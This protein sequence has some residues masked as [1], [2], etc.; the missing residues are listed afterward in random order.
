MGAKHSPNKKTNHDNRIDLESIEIKFLKLES[1]MF[2]LPTTM[3]LL[4]NHNSTH[5]LANDNSDK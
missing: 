2:L 3:E 5:F 4:P 1:A